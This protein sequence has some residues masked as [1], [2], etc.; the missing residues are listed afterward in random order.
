MLVETIA[1]IWVKMSA[2]RSH[3]VGRWRLVGFFLTGF[4]SFDNVT[5]CEI[6]FNSA[7]QT[8]LWR[9]GMTTKSDQY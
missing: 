9:D 8:G 6:S 7:R 2:R 3:S 4:A 1:L 5:F